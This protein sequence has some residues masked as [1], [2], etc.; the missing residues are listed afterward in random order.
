MSTTYHGFLCVRTSGC[1]AKF[2]LDRRE[3][4]GTL[5]DQISN[6]CCARRQSSR[7]LNSVQRAGYGTFASGHYGHGAVE[8]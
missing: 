1:W 3:S 4:F 7:L 5:P 2:G 8:L 6:T